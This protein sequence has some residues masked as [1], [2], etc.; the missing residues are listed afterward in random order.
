VEESEAFKKM[1]NMV[2]RRKIAMINDSQVLEQYSASEI[3]K[4]AKVIG[5]DIEIKERSNINGT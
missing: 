5:V 1:A 2:I 3:K 4:R